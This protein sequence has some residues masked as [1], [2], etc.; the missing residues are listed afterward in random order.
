M[1]TFF[2]ISCLIVVCSAQTD[3]LQCGS[4]EV[5]ACVKDCPPEKSCRNRG[6]K[7]NCLNDDSPCTP[8]CICAEGY[9]RNAIGTCITGEECDKCQGKNEF[10]ACDSACDNVCA[11]I[12]TQNRTKCPI[13]NIKC[14]EWCYCDDGY[15]RD[16]NGNCVPVSECR[17][18]CSDPNE[19]HTCAKSCP[20][21]TC[22]SLVAKFKCNGNE[23]CQERCACKPGYLRLEP[24]SPCIPQC[25]CPEL[26]NSPDC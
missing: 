20:P 16:A 6:I 12:A 5:E 18:Q 1:R 25:E 21:E 7:F 26:A 15:A 14:N 13:L 17:P 24:G 11:D 4:H 3:K 22:M 8:K 10:Y 2:V 19:V 9:Y 23:V